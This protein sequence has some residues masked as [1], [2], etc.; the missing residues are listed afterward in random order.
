M[1]ER[2][3]LDRRSFLKGAAAA[4]GAAAGSG[5][6]M[7]AASAKED[8]PPKPDK[9]Y[10]IPPG[11]ENSPLD[12]LGQ[13]EGLYQAACE[14]ALASANKVLEQAVKSGGRGTLQVRSA[15]QAQGVRLQDARAV[16]LA[17][18]ISLP[19][20]LARKAQEARQEG[21]HIHGTVTVFGYTVHG[22]V[23]W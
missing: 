12:D 13:F 20:L 23:S 22:H 7:A 3:D 16:K 6:A 5:L 19:P 4:I 15:L 10:G 8:K 18:N 9:I 21:W 1:E 11:D 2:K 14:Q 17:R